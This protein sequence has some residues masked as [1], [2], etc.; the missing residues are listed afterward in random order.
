MVI[1][2]EILFLRDKNSKLKSKIRELNK[3][4]KESIYVRQINM[5]TI[6]KHSMK[7]ATNTIKNINVHTLKHKQFLMIL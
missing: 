6:G 4:I 5:N 7:W 2:E 3:I 1:K